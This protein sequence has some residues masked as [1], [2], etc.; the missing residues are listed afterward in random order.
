[1][2]R[3]GAARHSSAGWQ[4]RAVDCDEHPDPMAEMVRLQLR[5]A[6]MIQ[7]IGRA[8]GVNRKAENPVD[9]DV[10]ADVSL[11]ITVNAV[12]M[13]QRPS[14]MIETAA[15]GVVLTAPVD[16]VRAWPH[17]WPNTIAADRMLKM[18]EGSRMRSGR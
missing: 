10:V 1:M 16:M 13:W 17:V 3:E 2:V 18:R 4:R 11:P 15:E 12:S 14:Q 9:I 5:E 6:E 8:R 7:A